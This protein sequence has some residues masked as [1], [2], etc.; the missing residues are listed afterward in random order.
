[1][2]AIGASEKMLSVRAGRINWP[3][4]ARKVSKSPVSRLSIR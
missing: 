2:R 1:M 4:A 3:N